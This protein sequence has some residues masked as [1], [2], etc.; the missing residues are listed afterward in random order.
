MI[1]VTNSTDVSQ[2][3]LI[4]TVE[5]VIGAVLLKKVFLKIC[6][7]QDS[8]TGVFMWILL[9]FQEHLFYRTPAGDCFSNYIILTNYNFISCVP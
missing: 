6:E 1:S 5:A 9:N 4:V 3:Y 2:W 8:G 7:I